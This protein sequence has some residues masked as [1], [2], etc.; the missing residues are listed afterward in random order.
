MLTE[1]RLLEILISKIK[2]DE[3]QT[4]LQDM[5]E[6]CSYWDVIEAMQDACIEAISITNNRA[7]DI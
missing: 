3:R 6:S 2:K 5:L 7:T 1:E 4:D